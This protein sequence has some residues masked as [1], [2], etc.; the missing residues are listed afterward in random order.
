MAVYNHTAKAGRIAK[1]GHLLILLSMA[2]VVNSCIDQ[3][4]LE[5]EDRGSLMTISGQLTTDLGPHQVEVRSSALF[6]EGPEGIPQPISGASVQ[7]TDD[8]GTVI[9]FTEGEPPGVY[10][11]AADVRGEV[12]R[13]YTLEVRTTEGKVYRS[14]AEL[15]LPVPEIDS[16][17]F[18]LGDDEVDVL[19]YT[20]IDKNTGLRWRAYG[21]YEFHEISSQTNLNPKICYVTETVD[22]NLVTVVDGASVNGNF[23]SAERAIT[24][25][26]DY[27][28]AIRYC[29]HV[30][31]QSLSPA[32]TEFWSTVNEEINRTGSI[33]DIPPAK[34]AG[35][36]ANV[37]DPDEEVLGIFYASAA[38]TSRLFMLRQEVGNP[39]PLCIP[40]PPPPADCF[41]CQQRLG[42][43][44]EKPVYWP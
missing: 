3:I 20:P 10:Y 43:T 22:L 41:N 33:F 44:T 19:V 25:N 9:E 30:I 6:R 36:M 32:A 35:N 2:L 23:L 34:I 11:S 28:F 38:D 5:T 27:R 8:L 24:K 4:D 37:D 26:V 16:L 12:G 39:G 15:M 1:W 7:V 18:A 29:M 21:E 13:T 42:A 17:S 31:Q 14:Q 40:F